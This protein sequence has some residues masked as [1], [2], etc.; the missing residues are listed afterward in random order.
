[1]AN[2]EINIPTIMLMGVSGILSFW[3]VEIN[4]IDAD[5][6]RNPITITPLFCIHLV[7]K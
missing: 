1:M 4:T 6:I 7:Q 2:P 3:L 5:K